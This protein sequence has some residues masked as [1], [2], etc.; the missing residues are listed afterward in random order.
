[1]RIVNSMHYETVSALLPL[2][3]RFFFFFFFALHV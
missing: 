3:M 2:S 1:M